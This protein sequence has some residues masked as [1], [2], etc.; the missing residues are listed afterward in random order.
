MPPVELHSK[1][2]TQALAPY[3]GTTTV[4]RTSSR[5]AAQYQA[6]KRGYLLTSSLRLL[7]L[8]FVIFYPFNF[9][10]YSNNVVPVVTLRHQCAEPGSYPSNVHEHSF[11]NAVHKAPENNIASM[12][13]NIV[14]KLFANRSR[15]AV[16]E[17][18]SGARSRTIVHEHRSRTY[19]HRS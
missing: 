19:G 7:L 16:H 17:Y 9:S 12:F 1:T 18:C 2:A 3:R 11:T 15:T 13:L 4:L 14:D 8:S 5:C 10:N 6:T